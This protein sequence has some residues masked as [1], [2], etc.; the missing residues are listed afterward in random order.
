MARPVVTF[1][2]EDIYDRVISLPNITEKR[3]FRQDKLITNEYDIIVD[4]SDNYFSVTN[5]GSQVYGTKWL[6]S[7]ITV[8]GTN[9]ETIWEGVVTKIPRDVESGRADITSKNKLFE[10]RKEPIE[11]ETPVG[12]W[13]TPSEA[14]KNICDAIG[15]TN[16]DNNSV[17]VSTGQYQANNCYVRVNIN[18]SDNLSFQQCIER[19]AIYGNADA[20]S[21]LNNIYFVHW[22]QFTGSG[23]V[24][25]LEKDMKRLPSGVREDERNIINDYSIDYQGSVTPA[26]DSGNLNTGAASRAKYGVHA[27]PDM[28]SDSS[29]IVQYKN[30]VSADY[31]GNSYIVRTHKYVDTNRVRPLTS[32]NFSIFSDFRSW[33]TLQ[34]KFDI[35]LADEGWDNTTCE[36]FEFTINEDTD[37]IR[38][39]AMEVV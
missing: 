15:Y 19:L 9:G 13:E 29:G 8:T 23:E 38:I 25:F 7:D 30:K 35:T 3:T 31:I 18:K 21:H 10:F 17:T 26:T 11:Y 12:T 32:F 24:S 16:Y 33:L 22:V 20:Y 1:L 6:Y 28:R 39:F 36:P 27:L 34:S 5:I 37:E 2:G 4:N 14:F